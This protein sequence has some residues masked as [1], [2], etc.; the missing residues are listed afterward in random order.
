MTIIGDLMMRMSGIGRAS[1]AGAYFQESTTREIVK[2]S[3]E[4]TTESGNATIVEVAA[5]AP[6]VARRTRSTATMLATW[7]VPLAIALL[8]LVAFSPALLN[9]FVRWDDPVLF[10]DNP[11]YRGLG[12]K[13]IRWMFTN[14]TMGHWVPLTWLSHGVDYTLWG[15]NPLGYHVTN[16]VLHALNAAL[17]YLLALRLLERAMR[18]GES[19]RMLAAVTAALFFALHPLRAESVAWATERRDVLSGCFFFLTLLVHLR[20]LDAEG[21][22]RRRLRLLSLTCF[23]L[24]F[25]S[26]SIVMTLPLVLVLLDVYPLRRLSWD[27]RT[28]FRRDVRAIWWEKLPY[29]CVSLIGALVALFAQKSFFTP[30][31]KTGLASRPL[32]AFYGLWFY[33]SKTALPLK[34]SPLYELPERIDP[35]E[36]RFLV[37]I[38]GVLAITAAVLLARR[39]WPAGLALWVYYGLVLAPVSGL[40]HAGFQL[41]HDRYSYLSCLGWALLVG[42]GIGATARATRQG[43]I[44]PQFGRIAGIAVAGWLLGLAV[45]TWQQVQIWKDT[46]TLWR[47]AVES[48]PRCGI[49]QS[50]L[51]VFL[52]NEGHF[53]LA[54]PYFERAQQ[55]RPDQTK[56]HK[57]VGLT[58]LNLGRAGEAVPH[59][60]RAVEQSAEDVESMNTLSVAL[61]TQGRYDEALTLLERAVVLKPDDAM[62]L[63]NLATALGE[64][65]RPA[66]SLRHLRTALAAAPTAPRPRITLGLIYLRLGQ[67]DAARAQYDQLEQLDRRLA[68]LL[69][70]ALIQDW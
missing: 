22:D 1:S 47:F 21:S 63:T 38:G 2:Q 55:L 31:A 50:N 34:L 15:M 9:G 58:L 24:A 10:D 52:S 36:P 4:M 49:C 65:G 60:R 25:L 8:V 41:A 66:E 70:A 11:R 6:D 68:P 5:L 3:M 30:V 44:R 48:E 29:L 54:L 43:R 45:L 33:V 32:I 20:A 40:V 56:Y 64:V 26:K 18:L 46:E 62:V 35:L 67:L 19:E 13:E 37:A 17:F 42:A 39:R 27:W 57:D 53:A 12:W 7:G 28:W 23:V 16:L 51:G 59:L 14:V 61:M 69:G